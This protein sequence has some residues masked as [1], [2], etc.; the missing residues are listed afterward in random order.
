MDFYQRITTAHVVA[1]LLMLLAFRFIFRSSII[2]A[3]E[4]E[5]SLVIGKN[6]RL[7]SVD[8]PIAP[9]EDPMELINNFIAVHLST[10]L[11]NIV[12]ILLFRYAISVKLTKKDKLNPKIKI[13]HNTGLTSN[14]IIKYDIIDVYN[15]ISM[16][17]G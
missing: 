3:V 11:F 2:N 14:E 17:S 16:K 4:P 1:S 9:L 8:S 13:S 10:V 6:I 7:M 12:L 15:P 5:P